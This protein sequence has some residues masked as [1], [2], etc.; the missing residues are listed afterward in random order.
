MKDYSQHL[1][2]LTYHH[3]YILIP[4]WVVSLI[5]SISGYLTGALGVRVSPLEAPD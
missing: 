3:C 5:V 1:A 4:L 2:H